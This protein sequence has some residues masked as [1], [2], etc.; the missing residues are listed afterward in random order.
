MYLSH[1]CV[2]IC[3]KKEI[4]KRILTIN[5]KSHEN[6]YILPVCWLDFSDDMVYH[7]GE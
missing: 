5:G 1:D 7:G 2:I 4:Q 3:L 6:N